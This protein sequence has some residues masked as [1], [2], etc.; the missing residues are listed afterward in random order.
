MSLAGRAKLILVASAVA[1][2]MFGAATHIKAQA[3]QRQYPKP[4]ELPNPYRLVKDWPTL[5]KSMNGGRW[6]EV[7]R[8]HVHSDGNIWVFHRCFNT[9]PPGHAT[10]IGRG[11]SNPPI[12][13]FDPSGKLLKSFGVGLFAYPHGFT[14][15][16]D[17][18]LWTSDV[19]DEAT[20]LG[21]SAKNAD[22]VVRGQEV[23]KLSPAGKVLMTIGKEGVSG[24]GPDTFDRPTGVAVAPNGDVFVTDGHLPNKHNSGR[25]VKFS[26]DGRFIK[27]WGHKGAAP[28]DFDEPHDIFI[29]GSQGRL[30]IADR[31]NN[32]IQVFD[33]DG[34]FLAAWT[35]FGQPSSVFVSKDDTIYVGAAFP[36]PAAKKGQLRGIVVGNAKDGSLKAF[37]PDPADPDK[38][39]VGTTASGIAADDA[40]SIYAA[41]VAAHNLRKYVKVK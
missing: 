25:V 26:K 36:D 21:M 2:A 28:G 5:P 11:D 24:N 40:G 38:L 16:G 9:V 10:C 15:D 29:G 23:L 8:V 14:I 30:Y 4:T 7:I 13:E 17:G 35:Q 32:R 41:D 6:G 33:L 12:L 34:K 1:I 27:S 37:I 3:Q 19:N 20:V 31:R 39:D 22:G 18:N